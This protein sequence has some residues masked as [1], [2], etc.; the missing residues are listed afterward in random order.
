MPSYRE[1]V[2]T[3]HLKKM[4]QPSPWYSLRDA[5]LGGLLLSCVYKFSLF[6][7]V[8]HSLPCG[9]PSANFTAQDKQNVLTESLRT[10][11]KSSTDT[12]HRAWAGRNYGPNPCDSSENCLQFSP[13][14]RILNV[15]MEVCQRTILPVILP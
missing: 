1:S 15:R 14:P 7:S 6:M 12:D 9:N 5:E 11:Y 8:S 3:Q 4:P 2:M 10:N 13:P